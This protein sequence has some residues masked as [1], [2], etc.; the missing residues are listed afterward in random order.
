MN[1]DITYEVQAKGIRLAHEA[2]NQI[3]NAIMQLTDY[4]YALVHLLEENEKYRN[5]FLNS[6]NI[7]RHIFLDNSVFELGEAAAPELMVKW[8]NVL[9]PE[10]Y[11]IPDV[12]EDSAKTLQ[13]IKDWNAKY[14]SQL[15]VQADSIGVVQGR[16]L[17]EAV[18]CYTQLATGGEV[19]RIAISFDYSFYLNQ[20]LHPNPWVRYANGRIEFISLLLN[21]GLIDPMIKHH[22]LGCA[23]PL[24]YSYYA[25]PD[26]SFINSADTSAPIVHGIERIRFENM[27]VGSW[28]KS[29]TK[30]AN[31]IDDDIPMECFDDIIDNIIAMRSW[32]LQWKY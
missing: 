3:F 19:D 23:H 25:S 30:V 22:L 28:S 8:I 16:T 29:K 11:F 27:N 24:E 5:N 32:T 17:E 4:D 14:K 13:N 12:L 21:E 2:P 10:A 15:N 31:I 26:F 6:R 20:G 1:D 18:E 9:L 7:G